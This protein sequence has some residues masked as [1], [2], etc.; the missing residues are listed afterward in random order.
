DIAAEALG[1]LAAAAEPE[2]ARV[3]LE[4]PEAAPELSEVL[5][6]RRVGERAARRQRVALRETAVRLR[7]CLL[8]GDVLRKEACLRRDV[9][10]RRGDTETDAGDDDR[11]HDREP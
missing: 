6:G 1:D 5:P 7:V 10:E 11:S 9:G 2:S 3:M 4:V 8:V